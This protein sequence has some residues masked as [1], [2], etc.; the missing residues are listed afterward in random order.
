MQLEKDSGRRECSIPICA[1]KLKCGLPSSALMDLSAKLLL[2]FI[3]GGT[4]GV[5]DSKTSFLEL[6]IQFAVLTPRVKLTAL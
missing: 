1:I 4:G 5:R 2:H 3:S 6:H